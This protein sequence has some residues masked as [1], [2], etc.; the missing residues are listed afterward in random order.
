MISG[1]RRDVYKICALLGYYTASCDNCLPTFRDNVSVASSRVLDSWPLKM[2]PIRCP[3]TSVNNYHTTSRNIP[4]GRRNYI[5]SF[6]QHSV[7]YVVYIG[8]TDGHIYTGLFKMIV[9]VL[10]TCHTQYTWDSS[11]WIFLFNR[12]T[13]QVFVT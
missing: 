13:L 12:T 3:E 1:I 2:G 5:R 9:W 6:S 11:R 8:H 7:L 10:T 4:E